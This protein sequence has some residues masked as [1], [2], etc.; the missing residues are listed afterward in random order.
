MSRLIK[1]G[2][3]TG[4][5]SGVVAGLLMAFCLALPVQAAIDSDKLLASLKPSG[6]VN[7]YAGA[8][9][10]GQKNALE[11]QLQSV[12]RGNGP[13][14]VVV[15][16]SSLQGGEIDDFANK[17]FA[18]WKIGKKGK[19][20]GVL[21]LAAIQ[22]RVMRIE[23]GYGLEGVLTDAGAGRIRDN[24]IIPRFKE[25]Q[26]AEGLIDG[27]QA[28]VNAV[29]PDSEAAAPLNE[30]TPAGKSGP[31]TWAI[32]IFWIVVAFFAIRHPRLFAMLLLMGG[33]GGGRGGS[34]GGGF[35]GFGGG[36]SGGGGASG[37]W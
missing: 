17:L 30:R 22:D 6:Y 3:R 21:L 35:G 7:D 4:L 14:I 13:E 1:T 19:D 24:V 15:A 18:R 28:I 27:A 23:V 12:A 25:N 33:R 36:S 32:V 26:Y 37:R 10:S 11:Q 31:P 5:G 34:G 8:F 9:D 29:A 16:L 20:N 2:W